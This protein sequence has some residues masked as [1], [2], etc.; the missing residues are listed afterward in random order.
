MD[1]T[2]VGN[3]EKRRR[4]EEG[5]VG[6]VHIYCSF[7]HS[8]FFST[9]HHPTLTPSRLL[10]FPSAFWENHSLNWK[11]DPGATSTGSVFRFFSSL[12]N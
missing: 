1:L 12:D 4:G 2:G 7:I 10:L 5:A 3:M 6:N 9:P 8:P 11:G